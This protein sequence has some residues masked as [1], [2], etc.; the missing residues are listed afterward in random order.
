MIVIELNKKITRILRRE[1][2]SVKT[3]KKSPLF[4]LLFPPPEFASL[5][6]NIIELKIIS[7]KLYKVA[8]LK[9]RISLFLGLYLSILL[10]IL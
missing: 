4:S 6:D 9:S 2:I 1:N 8:I 10:N 3:L 7:N 5:T